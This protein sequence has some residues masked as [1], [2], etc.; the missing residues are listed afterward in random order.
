MIRVFLFRQVTVEVRGQKAWRTCVLGEGKLAPTSPSGTIPA[1]LSQ[2]RS[3]E[4][5][6]DSNMPN[7]PTQITQALPSS[8]L[9]PYNQSFSHSS[10]LPT[11]RY[12]SNCDSNALESLDWD[13]VVKV[14]SNGMGTDVGGFTAGRLAVKVGKFTLIDLVS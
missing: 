7:V 10:D 1:S 5:T 2:F 12:C 11:P 14:D 9:V 13:G 6:E 4:Q 8:R 3:Q